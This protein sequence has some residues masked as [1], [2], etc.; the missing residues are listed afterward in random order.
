[1][2]DLET[3]HGERIAA[4]RAA[5]APW[6]TPHA[7]ALRTCAEHGIQTKVIDDDLFVRGEYVDD[8]GPSEFWFT[9]TNWSKRDL[10]H[11]LGH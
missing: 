7:W 4:R 1:M 6:P 2:N 9:A 10:L 11:W 3:R 8:T 5:N